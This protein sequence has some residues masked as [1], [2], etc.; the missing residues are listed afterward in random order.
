[1]LDNRNKEKSSRQKIGGRDMSLELIESVFEKLP[2][3]PDWTVKLLY[4]SHSKRRGTEYNSR[5]IEL[6]PEQRIGE[7]VEEISALYTVG[8]EKRLAKYKDVR[9]YDGTCIGDTIYRISP[10]TTNIN[11]ELESLLIGISDSDVEVNPLEKKPQGY[12]LCNDIEID[13]NKHSI[14]LISLNKPITT[15]K[16]RFLFNKG[17]FWELSKEVLNL[18]TIM[19]VIIYDDVVYFL[20]MSGEGLFNMDRAYRKKCAESVEKIERMKIISDNDVFEKIA[21]SG[22]NP[23]R[24]T[25]FNDS[26]LNLLNKKKNREKA[27]KC[28]NL[29]L[30]G[31][32]KIF[33][34]SDENVV[35]DLVKVL[36]DKA[37]W[38]VL[39]ETPVEVEGSRRWGA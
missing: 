30:V 29:P 10:D 18:R 7:L 9:E 35:G 34:T 23:R 32:N 11:I 36:C 21:K 17:K 31:D 25:S 37:M 3:S 2:S 38:D 20:D 28:F 1:M 19:N 16:N 4:Y 15:Y 24:F 22:H 27:A 6:E 14:K 13:G 5:R 12:V 39:E 26:K 33:D 8:Q